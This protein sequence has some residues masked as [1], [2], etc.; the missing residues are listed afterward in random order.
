MLE[1]LVSHVFSQGTPFGRAISPS[2]LILTLARY[3]DT[4]VKLTKEGS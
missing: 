1:N 4:K 2:S 3:G